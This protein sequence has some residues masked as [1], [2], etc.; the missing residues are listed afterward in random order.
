MHGA[1]GAI[2]YV[3]GRCGRAQEIA[4]LRGTTRGIAGQWRIYI[5]KF[6]SDPPN[7]GH[8]RAMCMYMYIHVYVCREVRG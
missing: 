5:L 2:H 6:G 4:R 3:Y 7:V 1:R 8:L